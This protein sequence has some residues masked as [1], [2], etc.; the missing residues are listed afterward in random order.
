M[1]ILIAE[2]NYGGRVTDDKDMRLIKALLAKYF[3]PKIMKDEYKFSE[4]GLYYSIEKLELLNIKEYIKSLPLDDD[5][6]V[7]G[8]HS[9]ANITFQSK[10]VKS[11]YIQLFIFINKKREFMETMINVSPR[12]TSSKSGES[13]DEITAKI[14]RDIE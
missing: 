4:S 13:P 10:T 12:V 11:H 6:E 14:A 8:L 7:F 9:N 5:P 1:N 3:T 2:I